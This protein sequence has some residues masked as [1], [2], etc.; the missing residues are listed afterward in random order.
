MTTR[1][2]HRAMHDADFWPLVQTMQEDEAEQLLRD[3]RAT[4]I[5]Q[6]SGKRP[7]SVDHAITRINPSSPLCWHPTNTASCASLIPAKNPMT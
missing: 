1:N 5:A 6:H 4:L 7:P 2:A 3:V